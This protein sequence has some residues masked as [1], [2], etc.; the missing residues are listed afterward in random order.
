M[1]AFPFR[2][3]GDSTYLN[4]ESGYLSQP[5]A[6]TRASTFVKEMLLK[7][8]TLSLTHYWET[9]THNS[10]QWTVHGN[11]LNRDTVKLREVTKQMD[12]ADIYRIF[13]PKTKEYTFSATHDSFSKTDHIVGHKTS[14]ADKRRL[15]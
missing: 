6:Y 8:K 2:V 15:K 3:P 12:L 14:S 7:L 10:H 11:K 5:A 9:S 1:S 4:Q 13:H